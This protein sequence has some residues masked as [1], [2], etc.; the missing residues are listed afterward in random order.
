MLFHCIC[1]GGSGVCVQMTFDLT[2]DGE[3]LPLL[4]LLLLLQVAV[5]LQ[6]G[7]GRECARRVPELLLQP[8]LLLRVIG[9]WVLL[10]LPVLLLFLVLLPVVLLLFLVLLLVG[11]PVLLRR[12]PTDTWNYRSL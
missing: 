5:R 1:S 11:L 2:D 12:W 7:L 10:R 6:P 8:L 9:R 4:G 3:H